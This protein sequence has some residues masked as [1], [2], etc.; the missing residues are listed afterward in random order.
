MLED[1]TPGHQHPVLDSQRDERDPYTASNRPNLEDIKTLAVGVARKPTPPEYTS[2]LSDEDWRVYDSTPEMKQRKALSGLLKPG[3]EYPQRIVRGRVFEIIGSERVPLSGVMVH[4]WVGNR[5]FTDANGKFKFM[6]YWSEPTE[7]DVR[8]G[9]KYKVFLQVQVHG[10]VDLQGGR[11]YTSREETEE[12]FDMY[13]VRRDV[14]RIKIRFE[15]PQIA[16][17]PVI[18]VLAQGD[19]DGPSTPKFIDWD[20]KRY[21]VAEVDPHEETWFTV[22]RRYYENMSETVFALRSVSAPNILLDVKSKSPISRSNEESDYLVKLLVEDT[23]TFQGTTTSMQTGMAI[24]YARIYGPG[25]CEFTVADEQGRFELITSKTPRG[26]RGE[27]I[28]TSEQRYL[29]IADELYATMRVEVDDTELISDGSGRL[30]LGPGG[31]LSGPWTFQLRPW[32]EASVDCSFLPPESRADA[33]VEV[34]LDIDGSLPGDS[35]RKLDSDGICRFPRIPWGIES[36]R[37]ST[38]IPFAATQYEIRPSSWNGGEPY[39]VTLI[40]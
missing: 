20:E 25:E 30:I 14:H 21:I 16:G 15:N 19:Y 36:I 13:V 11:T 23:F 6:A 7:D 4:D 40:E 1:L 37:L 22:P 17:G 32:V 10:Y 39:T 34:L 26:P 28:P 27:P 31:N 38:R 12:G 18:V 29:R 5:T 9:L 3:W 24:P 35:R 2:N 8:E 33:M